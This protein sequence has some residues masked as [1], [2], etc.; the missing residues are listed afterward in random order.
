MT[1]CHALVF[2]PVPARPQ[3][4]A[5]PRKRETV[6]KNFTLILAVMLCPGVALAQGAGS[7]P[8]IPGQ[9]GPGAGPGNSRIEDL[10]RQIKNLEQRILYLEKQAGI[11]AGGP[12]DAPGKPGQAAGACG[13]AAVPTATVSHVVVRRYLVPLGTAVVPT[14]N[15]ASALPVQS[16]GTTGAASGVTVLSAPTT[17]VAPAGVTTFA[18]PAT[19]LAPAAACTT[20]APNAAAVGTLGTTYSSWGAYP[21]TVYRGTGAVYSNSYSGAALYTG[22]GVSF[23]RVR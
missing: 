17:F 1:S 8:L 12:A 5:S 21:T 16:L 14:V 3:T 7:N 22:S 23:V 15:S 11:P 2:R 10:Q 20:V 4:V 13:Q 9:P 18:A 6:M 19:T